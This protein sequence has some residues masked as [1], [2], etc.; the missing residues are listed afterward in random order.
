MSDKVKKSIEELKVELAAKSEAI[1]AKIVAWNEASISDDKER[2]R[3]MV[4]IDDELKTLKKEYNA[5]SM[6]LT[7]EKLNGN[8][9]EAIKLNRYPVAAWSDSSESG[10]TV[11]TRTREDGTLQFDLYDFDVYNGNKASANAK[12][13]RMAENFNMLC[14]MKVAKD[15]GVT[16]IN[17]ISKD[18]FMSKMAEQARLAGQ[19]AA[20]ANPISSTQLMKWLQDVCDS[21]VYEA[22]ED[23]AENKYRVINHDVNWMLYSYGKKDR[24][25]DKTLKVANHKEFRLLLSDVMHRIVTG[26]SYKVA[27][28]I[29]K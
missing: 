13:V 14:C 15:I 8:M 26:T 9:L 2:F 20:L 19:D 23:K 28:Q 6:K 3:V 17:T 11:K 10:S 21:I 22:K 29:K 1:D 5:L 7:F 24:K 18:Y 16:D 25:K 12:W 27:Y 4:S